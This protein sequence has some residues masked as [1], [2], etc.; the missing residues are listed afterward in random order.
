MFNG[1]VKMT[2]IT[3]LNGRI[4]RVVIDRNNLCLVIYLVFVLLNRLIKQAIFHVIG[5]I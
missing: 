2:E 5:N 1:I 4:I 3:L